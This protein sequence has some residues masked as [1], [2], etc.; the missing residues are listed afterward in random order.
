MPPIKTDVAFDERDG[1]ITVRGLDPIAGG[2]PDFERRV[3]VLDALRIVRSEDKAAPPK[4]VGHAALFDS[5][6]E[7]L[8]GFRERIAP[9]AFAEA[10][11]KDDVRALF[12]HD[13][14]FI[15]GR[16]RSGTLKLAEDTRGLAIEITPP[17]NQ[18]I[19]DLVVAPIERGDVSQ[20]SFGFTVRP[21][22]QDWAKDDEGRTVRTL[23]RVRLFDV[24]PVVF[25]AYTATDVAMR[26][27]RAWQ[28]DAGAHY[29]RLAEA[30]LNETRALAD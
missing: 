20:M 22:G 14:N 12:N 15:I 8:G 6:S 2:L 24:S 17:D 23:K 30:L 11:T 16:N 19:R 18:T 1:V 29:P 13:P 10:I 3:A 5:L 7:D 4:I 27:L 9:G 28:E 25:P 26:A 21:G